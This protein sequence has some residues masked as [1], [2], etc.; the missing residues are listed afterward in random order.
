MNDTL[1]LVAEAKQ[2]A[3][4]LGYEIRE[5]P[6][7]ELPGGPC[8]VAGQRRILLNMQHA[9]AAHLDVLVQALAADESLATVPT[10]RLLAQ[11]LA[12]ARA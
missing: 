6:L 4:D 9:P 12:A 5:E 11:R 7:G 8:I 10:S 1:G 2:V 3:H